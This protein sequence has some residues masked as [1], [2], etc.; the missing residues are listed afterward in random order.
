MPLLV[1]WNE[2]E[3]YSKLADIVLSQVEFEMGQIDRLLEEYADL[4]DQA[5]KTPLELVEITALASVLHSF[6]NGVENIFSI[7]AK[8]IDRGMPDGAHWHRDLLTQMTRTAPN[9]APVLSVDLARR[10]AAYLGFRH[11][12]RHAYSF[13]LDWDEMEEL[14]T[15]LPVI[16]ERTK[17]ELREFL[18]DLDKSLEDG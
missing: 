11:F 14:V 13:F 18:G 4:L 15:S 9:R 17:G 7:I 3:S 6:Y 8:R 1:T 2:K 16:W 5:Q 12:Y 10:L